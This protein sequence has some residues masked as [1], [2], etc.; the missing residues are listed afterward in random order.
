VT[1]H[2]GVAASDMWAEFRETFK[3][4]AASDW[5]SNRFNA[6]GLVRLC[7]A[8]GCH[9]QEHNIVTWTIDNTLIATQNASALTLGGNNIALGVSDVNNSTARHPSLVFTVFDNLV[10]TDVPPGDYTGD[11][12]VDAADYLAWLK[13][14][15]SQVDYNTWRGN[16]GNTAPGAG[17]STEATENAGVPNRQPCC[18]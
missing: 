4:T 10:V 16:F 18:K 8:Q 17:S 15:G 7:L 13:K 6:S 5:P 3:P 14:S 11:G 12:R 1:R 9:R 2:A